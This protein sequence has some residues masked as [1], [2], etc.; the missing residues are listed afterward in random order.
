MKLYLVKLDYIAQ[1]TQT[2]R[3]IE[4]RNKTKA[5]IRSLLLLMSITR[6]KTKTLL[7]VRIR[8]LNIGQ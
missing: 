1:M 5:D 7:S 2:I 4:I 6:A 3:V 8:D